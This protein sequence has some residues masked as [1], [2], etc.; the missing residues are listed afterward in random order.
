MGCV[1]VCGGGG[2]GNYVTRVLGCVMVCVVF[3]LDCQRGRQET[4]QIVEA[5]LWK[6]LSCLCVS[7]LTYAAVKE[8]PLAAP[9]L[10]MLHL[11]AP[12]WIMLQMF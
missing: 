9:L 3:V 1:C 11:A 4:F 7:Y 10:V 8:V 12:P 5:H 2:M 6:Q